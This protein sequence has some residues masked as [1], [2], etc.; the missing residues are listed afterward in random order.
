MTREEYLVDILPEERDGLTGSPA[1]NG[2]SGTLDA[3]VDQA[4]GKLLGQQNPSNIDDFQAALANAFVEKKQGSRTTYEWQP[5]AYSNS[6]SA[7]D[8]GGGVTGAQAS[9][10]YRAKAILSDVLR[11]LAELKPLNPAADMEN[12][13]AVRSI[14][15]NEVNELVRE[16]GLPGGP[17][18]QRVDHDFQRLLGANLDGQS[19]DLNRLTQVLGLNRE[20]I[21]TV[22][23]EE[24]Y[25]NFLIL[26]DYV[27]S[28]E[29][30][31]TTYKE[32]SQEDAYLGP[33]LVD[34]SRTLAAVAESVKE[35]YRLMNRV[36]LGPNERQSVFVNFTDAEYVDVDVDTE[37]KFTFSNQFRLPDGTFYRFEE[38]G[39]FDA[40]L[41]TPNNDP[42]N[43]DELAP[44]QPTY[45]PNLAQSMTIAE[46]LD[47]TMEFAAKEGPMLVQSS[48][49]LGIADA[50]EEKAFVLM[51]LVQAAGAIAPEKLNSAM[52]RGGVMNALRD[53]AAQLYEVKRLAAAIR[54]PFEPII[55]L[56]EI[57]PQVKRIA[58]S[59]EDSDVIGSTNGL[60]RRIDSINNRADQINALS[61]SRLS[62]A[63]LQRLNTLTA[64]INSRIGDANTFIDS[65]NLLDTL[66]QPPVSAGETGNLIGTIFNMFAAT[67]IPIGNIEQLLD[68]VE[69]DIRS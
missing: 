17:R 9:L 20:S 11:L 69:A 58:L 27:T 13:E 51:V 55:N 62:L 47:W 32:D 1:S 10:Y 18:T 2:I 50:F 35:T 56:A 6:S 8:L 52:R 54:S 44:T 7:S 45:A 29:D 24:N 68:D 46:L 3:I 19:G 16:L 36:F 22:T 66:N 61:T 23:E 67:Q 41:I 43:S 33:Q 53:L 57:R 63:I 42:G 59:I 31:W 25:S 48:G 60:N 14:V 4:F 39:S 28:L 65:I 40:I 5:Y 37:N 34:L 64:Q 38:D 26:R 30:S 15:R 49:K 12:I 21:N